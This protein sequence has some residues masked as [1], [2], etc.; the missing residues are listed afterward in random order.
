MKIT[1]TLNTKFLEISATSIYPDIQIKE[2][3][4]EI[5][6]QIIPLGLFILYKLPKCKI[7]YNTKS[8]I[9][10]SNYELAI[11]LDLDPLILPHSNNQFL[12][13]PLITTYITT[14]YTDLGLC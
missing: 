5:L 8:Y 9:T 6:R 10:V 1:L 13:H 11:S 12:I 2:W 7:L 4:N 3:K 14:P